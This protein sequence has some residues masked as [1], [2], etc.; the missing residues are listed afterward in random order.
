MYFPAIRL[1]LSDSVTYVTAAEQLAI[2][3]EKLFEA[4]GYSESSPKEE[5][6]SEVCLLCTNA[7]INYTDTLILIKHILYH[8]ISHEQC[9]VVVV[10]M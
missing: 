3:R 9:C 1:V 5:Y 6:P 7:S 2:E 4:I 10:S 8:M